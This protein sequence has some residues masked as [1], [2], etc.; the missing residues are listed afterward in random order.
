M[1]KEYKTRNC[2]ICLESFDY[3]DD[4]ELETEENETMRTT[5][6]ES[7]A[8]LSDAMKP[9]DSLRPSGLLSC[10]ATSLILQPYGRNNSTLDKYGV[11]LRGADGKKIKILRCGHIFCEGCWK[12]WVHSG[13]GNPCN[14]PVCR[15]DV[16]K[17]V[18]NKHSSTRRSPRSTD[19]AADIHRMPHEGDDDHASI[20]SGDSASTLQGP[21]GD[22]N[23]SNDSVD[24][25]FSESVNTRAASITLDMPLV[26]GGPSFLLSYAGILSSSSNANPAR[27]ETAIDGE[28]TPLLSNNNNENYTNISAIKQ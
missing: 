19:D 16:G 26:G 10:T 28:D 12:S 25:H 3:G 17:T 20:H 13:C 23:T 24:D 5:S 9:D 4:K 27:V 6:D 15:Q 18:K 22:L 7:T 1:Q 14:C 11:P 2:P 21:Y 8:I